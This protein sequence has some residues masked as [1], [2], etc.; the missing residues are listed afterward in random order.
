MF[1]TVIDVSKGECR[2]E[3]MPGLEMLTGVQSHRKPPK[4][5]HILSP[6]ITRLDPWT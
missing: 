3:K 5:L 1:K 6:F 4:L 2:P